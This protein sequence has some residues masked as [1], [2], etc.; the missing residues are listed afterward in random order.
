MLQKREAKFL[1]NQIMPMVEIKPRQ[2]KLFS[3]IN[4]KLTNKAKHIIPI[5]LFPKLMQSTTQAW[6]HVSKT[7]I[8]LQN[9][10]ENY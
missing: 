9:Q 1:G 8:P 10:Q 4:S 3:G 2:H 5:T 6:A 7:A